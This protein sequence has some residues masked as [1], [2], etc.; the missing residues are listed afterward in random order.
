MN[1]AS[2]RLIVFDFDGTLADSRAAGLQIFATI[3]PRLNLRPLPDPEAARQLPTRVLLKQLGVPF[4]KLPRL[5]R[6]Y[7]TEAAKTAHELKL[8][9]GIRAMLAAVAP[10]RRLGIV[11]SNREDSIRAC[12]RANDAEAF[13]AFVVGS[14]KLFGKAR[15][16]RRVLTA[17][18]VPATEAVYVGD[19][20]RDIEAAKKA[21]LRN[22][23]VT[24]GFHAESLL[25]TAG[26]DAL[27]ADPGLLAEW[28]LNGA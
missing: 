16:L 1:P 17:E 27:L 20:V 19:E 23:A 15:L 26:P 6:E 28:L 4:W 22:I 13:F 18:R 10:G 5:I 21:G 25:T 9:P 12:L 7:Q 3:A 24:W 2:P 8:F 14:P 11:S